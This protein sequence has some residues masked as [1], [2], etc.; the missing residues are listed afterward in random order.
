MNRSSASVVLLAS[1]SERDFRACLESL[2][3]TLGL[4]DEVVCVV[5]PAD[6]PR[7][8]LLRAHPKITVLP[9]ADPEPADRWRA[10]IAATTHPVVVLLDGDVILTAHWLDQVVRAVDEPGVVAAGPRCH[11]SAGPQAAEVPESALGTVATFGA[12]ARR[13]RQENRGGVTDVD[14]LGAV[15]VAARREA[16]AA[17]PLVEARI[18]YAE[19]AAAGRIV[20]VD[21]ALVAHVGAAACALRG[22]PAEAPVLVSASMIVKNE[23]RVLGDS[24]DAVRDFVDEIVVY[25]TGSTDRTREIAAAHGARVVEGYWNDHF[26][27]ARNRGIDECRGEWIIVVD[28]DEAAAGDPDAL[29]RTL[30]TTRADT[31]LAMV[32]N[33]KDTGSNA[34][35]STRVFRRRFA[36]YRGRLHEQVVDRVTGGGVVGPK[37]DVATLSL[38]HSGYTTARIA[39]KDK[40]ARNLELARLAAADDSAPMTAF[41]N[42]ARSALLVGNLDEAIGAA[43]RGLRREGDRVPTLMLLTV[44]VRAYAEHGQLAEAHATL[45]RL[46]GMDAS[47]ATVVPAE[48]RLLLAEESYAEVLDRIRAFPDRTTDDMLLVVGRDQLANLE[49]AA[50]AGLERHEEAAGRLR[51]VLGQG[52]LPLSLV[53]TARVLERAGGG[54]DTVAEIFPADRLR[55]LLAA[56]VNEPAPLVDALADALWQRHEGHPVPLALGARV[57]PALTPDRA[58]EWSA[59]LRAHGHAADCPLL[60]LAQEKSRTPRDRVRAAAVALATFGDGAAVP[61][62]EQALAAVPATDH[63]TVIA[64]L[65]LLLPEVAASLTPA[66]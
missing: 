13:W 40:S 54:I 42:L 64:D 55:T 26:A 31:F 57:G 48:V 18:G 27:D 36:H 15:C 30:A 60:A 8:A 38:A 47:A 28:A 56:V 24:L 1:G 43:E 41:V 19:L 11:R 34:L 3:P 32:Y 58:L 65:R 33:A 39:A 61:L 49:I 23:E 2:A 29:R 25:D 17:V 22:T 10:G 21:G 66:D 44:L 51:A 46:R 50:L 4:R 16:L 62:L 5:D 37:L 6:R 59:R 63:E 53:T 35:W 9:L 7:A 45:D 52:D 12:F 20:V 14:A